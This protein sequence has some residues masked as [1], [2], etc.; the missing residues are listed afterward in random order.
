M[1]L[2]DTLCQRYLEP[3]MQLQHDAAVILNNF[4]SVCTLY[5]C[6]VQNE[7]SDNPLGGT[8]DKYLIYSP[9]F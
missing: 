3:D 4:T 8:H 9:L 2:M 5:V 6:W 1:T 7:P